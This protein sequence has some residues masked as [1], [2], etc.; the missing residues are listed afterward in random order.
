MSGSTDL[1]NFAARFTG[2]EL[3]MDRIDQLVTAIRAVERSDLQ[4]YDYAYSINQDLDRKMVSYQGDKAERVTRWCKFKE[5]FSASFVR[6]IVRQLGVPEGVV[7]DPF[8]GS[9]TT[10]FT[11][12]ELGLDAVGMELL[13]NAIE[14]MKV[15]SKLLNMDRE[16]A[17]REVL[18]FSSALSWE[19]P[20]PISPFRHLSITEGA[21]P[22]GNEHHL[23]R[24]LHEAGT[25]TNADTRCLLTFAAMCVLEE[26]SYTSKDGQYLRWDYRAR[27]RWNRGTKF[28]KPDIADFTKAI[29]NKCKQIAEDIVTDS[30]L[31]GDCQSGNVGTITISSGSSLGLLPSTGSMKC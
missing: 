16:R 11:S 17:S 20:G 31:S 3:T 8:A 9:G 27:R 4:K 29:T 1:R 18:R 2:P 10:L 6:Y 5:A 12:S 14:I 25:L 22:P 28:Q 21:F 19:K 7:L 23:S 26:I 30:S 13:P 15:R 24:Y